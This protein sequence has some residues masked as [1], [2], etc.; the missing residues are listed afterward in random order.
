MHMTIICVVSCAGYTKNISVLNR[1]L[2]SL[3]Q[4]KTQDAN[5]TIVVTTNN[6]RH[7]IPKISC[8]DSVFVSSPESGFVQ[9]NNLAVQKTMHLQS[10]FYLIINDDAEI[11]KNF[12][13]ELYRV[14]TTDRN[15]GDIYVP[16]IYRGHSKK[17]DSFG[18]EYFRTGY[19][20]NA[21]FP[22]ITTSLA[23]MSCLLIRTP[24]LKKMVRT[25]G[26][27]L[28]PVLRWYLDD[29]E[30]SIRALAIGGCFYKCDKLVAFH[31]RTFTWG[32]KSYFV[33]YQSFRNL[34][35]VII[36]TWPKQTIIKNIT[37]VCLWQ[38][39]TAIYCLVK[40]S[41]WMYPKIIIS[42]LKN[43]RL[44]RAGR[45]NVLSKY[46]HAHVFSSLFSSLEVRHDVLTF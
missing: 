30:F 3:R 13:A 4:A 42:S 41:P 18:V 1:C 40:Y 28:N 12:F 34:L 9:I 23:S 5:I 16:Y 15:C 25:Y 31:K 32:E 46:T 44:L 14:F 35:W 21:F 37:R 7:R 43:W 45:K 20:K 27:F 11:K 10:D 17:L 26:F 2:R 39:T 36:L 38:L 6:P 8:I 19:S 24:F 29:V 33:M 22:T